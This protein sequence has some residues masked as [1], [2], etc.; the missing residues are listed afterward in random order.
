MTLAAQEIDPSKIT[1]GAGGLLVFIF[2]IVAG[3]FLFRSLKK[4]LNRVDFT[5]PPQEPA[6]TTE[7]HKQI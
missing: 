5:E 7:E 3:A 4:Q 6:S 1:P 2:L